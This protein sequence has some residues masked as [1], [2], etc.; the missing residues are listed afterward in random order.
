M[1]TKIK[2]AG[3]SG[4][5][6]TLVGTGTNHVLHVG[7]GTTLS[8]YR[9]HFGS[10]EWYWYPFALVPVPFG[11]CKVVPVPLLLWYQYPL[12]GLLRNGRFC[13]VHSLFFHKPLLLHPTSKTNM[14]SLQNNSTNTYNDG[15]EFLEP[16][17][18]HRIQGFIPKFT[19]LYKTIELGRIP[20][21][22]DTN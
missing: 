13:P 7:T 8:R 3:S 18:N 4:I 20:Y 2:A 9:Y 17:P 22:F 19:N 21:L 15:L 14:D 11:L 10:G 1:N 5:G 6:T 12:A 16:N